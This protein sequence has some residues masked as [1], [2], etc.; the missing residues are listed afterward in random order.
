MQLVGSPKNII[1]QTFEFVEL[2]SKSI[3]LR[4]EQLGNGT[5]QYITKYFIV[6]C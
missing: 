1:C 3:H 5:L 2:S 4:R 6:F